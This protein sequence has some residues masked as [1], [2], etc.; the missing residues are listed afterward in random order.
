MIAP[1]HTPQPIVDRLNR[2]I[3]AILHQPDI[4]SRLAAD[5]SELVGST[6][7]QFGQ[8]IKSEV[9]KWDKLAKQMNIGMDSTAGTSAH[10]YI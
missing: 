3:V 6:S 2:E 9:A 1:L 7:Q 10:V 4:A 5:G 8:H